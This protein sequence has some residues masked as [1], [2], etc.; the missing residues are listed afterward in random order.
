MVIS[1]RREGSYYI[2]ALELLAQPAGPNEAIRKF[3][4]L[5]ERLPATPRSIWDASRRRDFDIGIE[6]GAGRRCTGL[7][8][9]AQ[10]VRLVGSLGGRI[11]LTCYPPD[12]LKPRRPLKSV[13]IS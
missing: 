2:A 7:E 13:V 6:L 8:L 9:S 10:T 5:I 4:R 1:E 3:A 12:P 11:V